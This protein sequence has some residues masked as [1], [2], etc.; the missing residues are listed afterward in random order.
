METIPASRRPPRSPL[1]RTTNFGP[2]PRDQPNDIRS[3]VVSSTVRDD[4]HCA[5]QRTGHGRRVHDSTRP[6]GALGWCWQPTSE[7]W[8]FFTTRRTRSGNCRQRSVTGSQHR[9]NRSPPAPLEHLDTTNVSTSACAYRLNPLI[10]QDRA[11]RCQIRQLEAELEELLDMH[12]STLR[13]PEGT[14]GSLVTLVLNSRSQ[15]MVASL[16]SAMRRSEAL[17]PR[18]SPTVG[19]ECCNAARLRDACCS[20]LRLKP[21]D[22]PRWLA[23][24][25][26]LWWGA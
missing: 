21:N 2:D 15:P 7:R 4:Q 8:P 13:A 19:E 23:S 24:A 11:A 6:P 16:C 18:D 26:V 20:S 12:G 9:Q 22:A 1:L 14:L 5:C 17:K 3:R 10:E 25:G